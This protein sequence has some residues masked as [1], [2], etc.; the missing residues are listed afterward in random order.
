MRVGGEKRPLRQDLQDYD[1]RQRRR[2]DEVKYPDHQW[3][4]KDGHYMITLGESLLPRYKI[5]KVIGEGTFGKVTQ[6]W[7]R[8]EKK[9][10]AIKIIK[11]IQ[12]Y[13]DAAKVEISILKDIERKDKNGTSGCIRMLEAFDFRGHFCLVFDLLGMSMYDFLRQNSYR[14]FSLNEVQIFGKQIL[15]AVSFLHN[16]GLIH[17]DLK[18]ENV[19]LVNSDWQYHRHAVHGRSRVVKRKDVV[20]IDLG[21]AIYEKDHHATVVSTRHYRAPEVVLGMGW[22]FPCDLWSVGCILLELFT[23]EATFQTHENMEHLA[24]MEKIFGKIPLHIVSRVD[25]KESGRYFS[26]SG[27]LRWSEEATQDSVRAVEKLKPL[28]S[29][30]DLSREDH[31]QFYDLCRELM[32]LDPNSRMTASASLNHPFFQLNIEPDFT[33]L[34]LLQYPDAPIPP[35]TMPAPPGHVPGKINSTQVPRNTASETLLQQNP[36]FHA[37][38]PAGGSET[39]GKSWLPQDINA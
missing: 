7:D 19:L 9:Y 6:C 36:S 31:R 22:S 21:S 27:E 25:R 38:L 4:D 13:R 33:D 18:L 20:V 12:K 8:H 17:T 29:M 15:N 30:F 32:I 24:M 37:G 16:M 5:L 2:T 23:G 11:S 14:P 10:V 39:S 3:D 1:P 34:T 35:S 28:K 26:D